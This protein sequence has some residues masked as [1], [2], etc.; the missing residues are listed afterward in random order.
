MT[1]YFLYLTAP[2]HLEYFN[3]FF[4]K[5][6]SNSSISFLPWSYQNC[7]SFSRAATTLM[8]FRFLQLQLWFAN[9]FN[10]LFT[11]IS[12]LLGDCFHFPFL[13]SYLK[14]F[15][16]HYFIFKYIFPKCI[17]LLLSTLKF[18]CQFIIINL[19]LLI[20]TVDLELIFSA[21]FSR[22]IYKSIK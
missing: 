21:P 15:I 13:C 22:A 8:F 16:T 1:I 7:T 14:T 11:S 3:I 20:S 6:L 4:Q 19:A 18:T 5:C 9:V 2:K 17:I 12:C 10:K